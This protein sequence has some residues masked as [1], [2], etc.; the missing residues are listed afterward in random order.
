MEGSTE[1]LTQLKDSNASPKRRLHF[2]FWITLVIAI[3]LF[4]M[5]V[6]F[7]S[8]FR[9]SAE[10]WRSKDGTEVLIWSGWVILGWIP[11]GISI[12]LLLVLAIYYYRNT[13]R[14]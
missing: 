10:G 12:I 2:C 1:D 8:V 3:L 7:V 14:E 9:E 5:G 13:K 6:A 11:F 4:I